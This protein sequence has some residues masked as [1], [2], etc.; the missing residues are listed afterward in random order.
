M[1]KKTTTFGFTVPD[2][3]VAVDESAAGNLAAI[4]AAIASVSATEAHS[5]AG[6]IALKQGTAF[7]TG[8]SALAMTLAAPTSGAQSAG[9]DDG[10]VLR[11]VG[12]TAQ[13]HT[14]TTPSNKLNGA[15]H[16]ATFANAGDTLALVAYGGVWY[17]LSTTTT[18]S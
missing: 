18:L 6:A 4:D 14:V 13:A 5:T 10:K 8:S 3:G 16:V 1:S 2:Y 15:K 11:I 17:V 9:G 12:T 7:V